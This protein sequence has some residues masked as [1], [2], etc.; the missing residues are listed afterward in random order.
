MSVPPV[1]EAIPALS[2]T[3]AEMV[4]PVGVTGIGLAVR[5]WMMGPT[6]PVPEL[7]VVLL[8]V[9]ELVP[10]A[11]LV[12]LAE[13]PPFEEVPPL[14]PLPE[15]PLLAELVPLVEQYPSEL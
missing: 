12:L 3:I 4:V 7:A 5:L 13:L 15:L 2:L 14:P 8:L 11:E 1:S 9:D 10:L 6:V